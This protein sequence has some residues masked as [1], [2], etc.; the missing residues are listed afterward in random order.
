MRVTSDKRW[1][2]ISYCPIRY[3]IV[4]VNQTQH[5]LIPYTH[6]HTWPHIFPY[7][8]PS[9]SPASRLHVQVFDKDLLSA[10]DY[11][12]S[13]E[14]PLGP[15]NKSL[16]FILFPVFTP[17]IRPCIHTR[18]TPVLPYIRPMHTR[19]TCMY[20]IYIPNAPLR[21]SAHPIYTPCTPL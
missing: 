6:L 4:Q 10:N 15:F 20:T 3:H 13:R 18:Y 9:L 21:T 1:H 5:R 11:L 12:A 17:V 8:P 14:I 2:M 16:P 19:Y 7:L